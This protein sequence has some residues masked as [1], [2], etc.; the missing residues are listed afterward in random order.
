MICLFKA[1]QWAVTAT[2]HTHILRLGDCYVKLT[3]MTRAYWLISIWN[4]S[5]IKIHKLMVQ[6]TNYH[7][8]MQSSKF[9][10]GGLFCENWWLIALN[11][12][13][14]QYLLSMETGNSATRT[15][16]NKETYCVPLIY[17]GVFAISPSDA[18]CPCGPS[19]ASCWAS[20]LWPSRETCLS[21]CRCLTWTARITWIFCKRDFINIH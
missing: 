4:V 8:V 11:R 13:L 5:Y 12:N 10:R 17:G 9:T 19:M 7:N 6:K 3:D 18:P 20:D 1:Y 15:E 14:F 16:E 21:A 2:S